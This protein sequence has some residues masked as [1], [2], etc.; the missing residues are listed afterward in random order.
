MWNGDIVPC[1]K[2]HSALHVFGNLYEQ[3]FDDIVNSPRRGEFLKSVTSKKDN[4]LCEYCDFANP[5]EIHDKI[6]EIRRSRY[7]KD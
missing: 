1:C 3:T 4:G 2:D 5:H 7:D 6:L